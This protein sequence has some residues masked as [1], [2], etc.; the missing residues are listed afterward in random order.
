MA[1]RRTRAKLHLVE[2]IEVRA[3]LVDPAHDQLA[4]LILELHRDH[5]DDGEDENIFGRALAFFFANERA[6]NF[7]QLKFIHKRDL[8]LLRLLSAARARDLTPK[9]G[10]KKEHPF[11]LF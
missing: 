7:T 1:L 10:A 6:Q 2:L 4:D 9:R 3:E 8:F 5:H 11:P